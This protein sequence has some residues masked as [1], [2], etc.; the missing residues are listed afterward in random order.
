MPTHLAYALVV[1]RALF[2]LHV[3]EPGIVAERVLRNL[4]LVRK[5]ALAEHHIL[6]ALPAVNRTAQQLRL[7]QMHNFEQL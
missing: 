4:L 2:Q 6:N 3:V 7:M 5:A 1:A